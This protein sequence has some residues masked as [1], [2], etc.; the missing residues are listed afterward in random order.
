MVLPTGINL[1]QYQEIEKDE[2]EKL[3]KTYAK[4]GEVL[5]CSVSR[6]ALEKNIDF[7]IKG[8]KYVNENSTVEFKCIIIG[9]G[10]KRESL[11][12]LI[13]QCEL[14]QKVV[15]MGT[16]SQADIAKYYLASDLFV[17]SSLSETQGMVLL[18]AMAGHCPVVSV[19]SSGTDDMIEN[20]YNGYKTS[21]NIKEWSDKIIELLENKN[22][23]HDM[24]EN[25]FS[26]VQNFSV[27]K[28]AETVELFYR[29]RI[30]ERKNRPQ[31]D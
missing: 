20:G 19:I 3:K 21:E 25:A 26:Y 30:S 2:I 15:L 28:M 5:L 8:L 12:K 23:L 7:L 29:K 13:N 14:S 16:V 31:E 22:L 27:D 18:E 6:L 9:D 24:S 10:P 1:K 11:Q 4:N 17:F